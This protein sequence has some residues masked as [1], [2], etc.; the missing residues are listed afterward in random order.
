[1]FPWEW[2]KGKRL[3]ATTVPDSATSCVIK[4]NIN[5]KGERI[6]HMPGGRWYDRTKIEPAR[7]ERWFCAE[8]EA[9]AGGWRRAN[10]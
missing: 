9:I 1:M 5:S 8:A 3:Q 2:R 6:Y 7:G 4:G 10:R